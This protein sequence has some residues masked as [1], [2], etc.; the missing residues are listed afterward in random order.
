MNIDEQNKTAWQPHIQQQALTWIK[1]SLDGVLKQLYEQLQRRPVEW[2]GVRYGLHQ[3]AGSL[4]MA[5]QDSLSQWMR[6]LEQGAY[7]V[8]DEIKL[9]FK[10]KLV[11]KQLH[12]LQ[13]ELEQRLRQYRG[14]PLWIQHQQR[15]WL[16]HFPAEQAPELAHFRPDLSLLSLSEDQRQHW[17]GDQQSWL[18]RGFRHLVTG[19]LQEPESKLPFALGRLA[20]T[21]QTLQV[22]VENIA[23][24]RIGRVV[25]EQANRLPAVLVCR[26]LMDLERT[27]RPG[28][29]EQSILDRMLLLLEQLHSPEARQLKHVLGMDWHPLQGEAGVLETAY[30]ELAELR[31]I[32][33]E[34][35]TSAAATLRDVAILLEG[36]GWHQMAAHLYHMQRQLVTHTEYTLLQMRPELEAVLQQLSRLLGHAGEMMG[37]VHPVSEARQAAIREAR[38]LLETVKDSYLLY[39]AHAPQT[40][41][42]QEAPASLRQIQGMMQV[43]GLETSVELQQGTQLLEQVLSQ[44]QVEPNWRQRELLAEWLEAL[45]YYL[46]Q[47]AA[48]Y[49]DEQILR[50]A[51]QALA[52]YAAAGTLPAPT[53]IGGEKRYADDTLEPANESGLTVALAPVAAPTAESAP[54]PT[55]HKGQRFPAPV[56]IPADDF[57][58]ADEDIRDIFNEEVEEVLEHI[59]AHYPTWTEDFSNQAALKEFRRGFHTLKGSGRMV[60]ATAV[61][62]L[63]WSI[64]NMLNR[65]IDQTITPDQPMVELIGVVLSVIPDLVQDFHQRQV[66]RLNPGYLA[67]LANEL[68]AQ[69]PVTSAQ[70]L[71]AA[72]PDVTQDQDEA[73]ELDEPDPAGLANT[74]VDNAAATATEADDVPLIL[75]DEP[76]REI[77][78]QEAMGH[79]AFIAEQ[80]QRTEPVPADEQLVRAFHT[81]RGTAGIA[82]IPGIQRLAEQMELFCD[83]LVRHG[84]P[85]R[86]SH[87]GL[88]AAIHDRMQ[89]HIA[90]LQNLTI[91]PWSNDDEVL[92]QRLGTVQQ[93]GSST[94][95]SEPH[96]TNAEG[97]IGQLLALS[98]EDFLDAE[99]T[100]AEE[101]AGVD[102]WRHFAQQAERLVQGLQDESLGQ[103]KGLASW[104]QR[105]YQQLADHDLA[106]SAQAKDDLIIVHQGVTQQFDALA[107]GTAL[108]TSSTVLTA[109][110]RLDQWLAQTAPGVLPDSTSKSDSSE[111]GAQTKQFDAPLTPI[112]PLVSQSVENESDRPLDTAF[113]PEM[114]EIFLEEATELTDQLDLSFAQW[115]ANPESEADLQLLQRHMH[116]LKGGARMAGVSSIGDLS[117]EVESLYDLLVAG[118]QALDPNLL[119][120]IQ[121]SQDVMA[122]QVRMLEQKGASFHAPAELEVLRQYLQS[123]DSG[124]LAQF[125]AQT[126]TVTHEIAP[127]AE[128]QDGDPAQITTIV[129]DETQWNEPASLLPDGAIPVDMVDWPDKRR[130]EREVVN[131]FLEEAIPLIQRATAQLQ[132]WLTDHDS[133]HLPELQR[134][135]HTLKGGAR[136]ANINAISD[137]SHELESLYE[138]I[139]M[140]GAQPDAATCQALLRA[141]E[142]LSDA[143][144]ATSLRKQPQEPQVLLNALQ[145]ARQRKWLAQTRGG[146]K[147]IAQAE[148]A[149]KSGLT[150]LS[151][152]TRLPPMQG[153]FTQSQ[154]HERN[155]D[156]MIRV[157]SGLM[158]KLINLSGENAINR[159]RLEIGLASM[160]HTMEDMG[161]TIQRLADQLRRMEG[162]LE[163]QILAREGGERHADFDPLEMDQY[164]SLNQLSKS[165]A[166][167]SSDLL[168]LKNTLLDRSRESESLLL[169]QSRIQSEIAEGLMN[170][171]LV[172]FSRLVPRLSRVVRQTASE[173]NKL[174]ELKVVQAESEIDRTVLER[175][176]APLEHMLRNAVDHGLESRDWRIAANKPEVGVIQLMVQRE[177]NEVVITLSDDGKGIDVVA[178][179]R[180][181]IERG[182]IAP[183]SDLSDRDVIQFIFHAGLS[184][185]QSVTQVS[186]RGVGMDVVQSEIKQL[187]GVVT[188]DT[189]P[190]QGTRFV[191]R[192]PLTVAVADALVV[193]TGERNYAVSLTQIERI[194]RLAPEALEQY[195]QQEAASGDASLMVEGLAYRLHYLGDLLGQGKRPMALSGSGA[196]PVM[197]VK[198][199]GVNTAIQIDQVVGS[200]E[201]VVI[202][203]V[204]QQLSS[205][206]GLAGATI[207]GDGSVML[208]LDVIA[209]AR[210]INL[211][212]QGYQLTAPAPVMQRKLVMVVDDSVTVRKVTSRF[213][214]RSGFDV[215]TAKDGMDAMARLEESQPD[216]MLL[217]VEMP[218]M[219][220]FE[221][222]TQVRHSNIHHELPIIMI[223]SRTGAKHRERALSMGVNA[224]LGKPYQEQE[225]L[226]MIN[227]LT[228]RQLA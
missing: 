161:M 191:L 2:D 193:R 76:L 69:R 170:S 15:E 62:E 216:I 16:T 135:L 202:K 100:L 132:V 22:S 6:T 131:V 84:H 35:R 179:R 8:E 177:G 46:D 110:A 94:L 44:P 103:L 51:N 210:S 153:L 56:V 107:A 109:Q 198:E 151:I 57:D 205:V 45:E 204:G 48:G 159:A 199:A 38:S 134:A 104:L 47:L 139:L 19:Q 27:L 29:D 87:L 91:L 122:S 93:E 221:V 75:Q 206:R 143:L 61:G 3:L 155:S 194:V 4:A 149:N 25:L 217:D 120:F 175:V 99:W 214:E 171:R 65:V 14:R 172:P 106:L 92:L 63:A 49:Q 78:L 158:E 31:Q 148:V 138:T 192:L 23:I 213:L 165:L 28:A 41:S 181:A 208:I 141:H 188:V 108:R 222:A 34:A 215:I 33:P 40:E 26:A 178:V 52:G 137:L 77:F 200:R 209:L 182:L 111:Q 150:A 90:A 136:V 190:G 20:S 154:D 88:L 24:W 140:S 195:Y 168:D 183:D 123:R 10:A 225:L 130:P 13:D 142:W 95:S 18:K 7:P 126:A 97:L 73:G 116:T 30:N 98:I 36:T 156:E 173:L 166:E 70:I 174:A 223:T 82:Q 17:S 5:Q 37:Q 9:D 162:E 128:I 144:V 186:G 163:T 59:H 89:Q 207:L 85:L 39:Q 145:Q 197:I 147:F 86:G 180:K 124:L 1:P 105:F 152:D 169:Q 157:S 12:A 74:H 164:S 127:E 58:K 121:H 201:E 21:I 189:Q 96:A 79:L 53:L 42:L 167:S 228:E 114:M 227:E 117:H 187:G 60:G 146:R 67:A 66:P 211:G 115:Q 102:D 11:D 83:H 81:L 184:T 68:I 64:E 112:Q 196:V 224:Y 129:E 226:D 55:S 50:Q 185:A 176:T 219:D 125:L 160:T 43:L 118:R 32:A 71:R 218:R 203:P 133:L 212:R 101:N 220:G 54:K 80:S 113:D 72:D 119:R